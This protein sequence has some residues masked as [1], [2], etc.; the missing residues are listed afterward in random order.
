MEENRVSEWK[1]FSAHGHRERGVPYI[2][3]G[4]SD[5]RP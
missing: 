5:G 4:E 3:L 2:I 1:T